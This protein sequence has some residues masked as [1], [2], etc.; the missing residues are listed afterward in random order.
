MLN[1]ISAFVVFTT[2]LV[3]LNPK[4]NEQ[5]IRRSDTESVISISIL[6]SVP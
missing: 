6:K 4:I 5:T 3:D 1:L 2:K